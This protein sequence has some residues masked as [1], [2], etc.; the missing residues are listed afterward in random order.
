MLEAKNIDESN[1]KKKIKGSLS[2]VTFC[3]TFYSRKK[4]KLKQGSGL[5][6]LDFDKVDNVI[7]FKQK[8]KNQMTIF[9]QHGFLQVVTV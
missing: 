5:S 1:K 9:F 2:A 6:I 8:F 7:D 4:D 3:G